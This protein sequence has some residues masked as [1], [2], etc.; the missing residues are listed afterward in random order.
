MEVCVQFSCQRQLLTV[1]SPGYKPHQNVW[2]FSSS[3]GRNCFGQNLMQPN[4]WKNGA[5]TKMCH[6]TVFYCAI[7]VLILKC[8]PR[9]PLLWRVCSRDSCQVIFHLSWGESFEAGLIADPNF[10]VLLCHLTLKAFLKNPKHRNVNSWY[11]RRKYSRINEVR[12]KSCFMFC[13]LHTFK[14]KIAVWIASSN[15]R[16]LLY[17]K[18]NILIINSKHCGLSNYPSHSSMCPES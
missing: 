1:N 4:Q 12:P 6:E 8:G 14:V 18:N 2:V 5:F 3:H 16:S 17:L 7:Y 11:K 10:N 15:S 9:A 13:F